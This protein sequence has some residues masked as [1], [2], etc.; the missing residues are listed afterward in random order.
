MNALQNRKPRGGWVKLTLLVA[1]VLATYAGLRNYQGAR[2]VNLAA[3]EHVPLIPVKRADLGSFVNAPGR[4]ES[5]NSTKID[6][7]IERVEF[8]SEGRSLS[9]GGSAVILTVV[10]EG[11]FVKKDDVL[12]TI[13]SAEYVETVRQQEIKVERS[14]SDRLQAQLDLESAELAVKEFDEGLK[15][16]RVQDYDGSIALAEADNER[17]NERLEWSR[18]MLDKGYVPRSQLLNDSMSLKRSS[19]SMKTSKHTRENFIK[20]G[21]VKQLLQLKSRVESSK[22]RLSAEEQKL[23]RFKERLDYYKQMVENCTIR[24]PHDGFLIY[25]NSEERRVRI[26][27][28]VEVRQGQDLFFLPDLTKMEVVTYLHESVASRVT[29]GMPAK[30]K[31]EALN[32][33]MLEGHVQSVAPLPIYNTGRGASGELK[34]FIAVVKLHNVPTGLKPGMTASVDVLLDRAD[35]VL[36]VPPEAVAY[37]HG[38]GVC[39]VAVGNGLERREVQLGRSTPDKLEILN[40]LHD[41]DN[42]VLAPDQVEELGELVINAPSDD[43]EPAAPAEA[44]V[45]PHQP[46]TTPSV[47]VPVAA[48]R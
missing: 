42:I 41:G 40:G 29:E 18:R 33:R 12:C 47:P 13:D 17:A 36:T 27:P 19:L 1:T 28:G 23:N 48:I 32:N 6:C 21:A 26:E 44:T 9:T 16:Q 39:Y 46:S 25:A 4:V 14:F 15:L 7:K 3:L 20:F 30:A 37:E 31:I 38:H 22:V 34:Y 2:R 35:D 45:A 24:A 11:T 10:P 5:S 8:R 43:A